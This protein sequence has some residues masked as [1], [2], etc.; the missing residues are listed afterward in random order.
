MGGVVRID[1]EAVERTQPAQVVVEQLR[2]RTETLFADEL[3][4][5]ER[6]FAIEIN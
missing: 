6:I 2:T 3:S 4:T 1:P 5:L